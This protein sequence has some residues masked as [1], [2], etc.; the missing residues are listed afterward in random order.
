[1]ATAIG[2]VAGSVLKC[3]KSRSQTMLRIEHQ[4]GGGQLRAALG[5]EDAAE[6]AGDEHVAVAHARV[7]QVEVLQLRRA[8][9]RER[10]R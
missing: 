4:R 1:M 8:R 10:R 6:H 5:G 9:H 3:R 2:T 7:V